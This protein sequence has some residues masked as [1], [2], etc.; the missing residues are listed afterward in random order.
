MACLEHFWVKTREYIPDAYKRKGRDRSVKSLLLKNFTISEFYKAAL[1]TLPLQN[2]MTNG[3]TFFFLNALEYRS[4]TNN[5]I[6]VTSFPKNPKNS[7]K[8]IVCFIPTASVFYTPTCSSQLKWL[9][10]N[11]L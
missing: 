4:I 1:K 7:M 6:I 11:Y 3:R 5:K 8:I 2:T 9:E 10:K